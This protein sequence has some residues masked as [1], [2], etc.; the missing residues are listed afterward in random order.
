VE[1]EIEPHLRAAHARDA[2]DALAPP[3]PVQ[4]ARIA[5]IVL[6]HAIPIVGMLWF[7]WSVAQFL[8]LTVFN[9]GLTIANVGLVGITAMT[10]RGDDGKPPEKFG[11]GNLPA[12]LATTAFIAL[13]LTALGGW[14]IFVLAGVD[15]GILGEPN[16]WWSAL[17]MELSAAPALLAEIRDKARSPLSLEQLK[18]RDQPRVGAAFLGIVTSAIFSAWAV[19]M[20]AFG[21]VFAVMAFTVFGLLRELRPDW[22]HDALR[23][24][25]QPSR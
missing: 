20:G 22:I 9:Y 6:R 16:L 14:P 15:T 25:R 8:L 12:L 2:W 13:L 19:K 1:P 4:F 5:G 3:R 7:G 18:A 23:P 24:K 10:L 11:I 21:V 17:A